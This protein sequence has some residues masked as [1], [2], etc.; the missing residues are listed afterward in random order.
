MVKKN[1]Q[2]YNLH[3]TKYL[4]QGFPF[5]ETHAD[6]M[7]KYSPN[8]DSMQI[9]AVQTGKPHFAYSFTLRR[10]FLGHESPLRSFSFA[11][12]FLWL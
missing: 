1:K 9:Y 10:D 6:F 4:L 12:L 2:T 5:S 7:Q 3:Y 11:Q 8:I